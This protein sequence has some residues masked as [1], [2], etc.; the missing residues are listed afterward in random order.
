MALLSKKLFRPL[1]QNETVQQMFA[2]MEEVRMEVKMKDEEMC[3]RETVLKQVRT[4]KE[5]M[6]ASL[7]R[8]KQDLAR[9]MTQCKTLEGKL[10]Q[11]SPSNELFPDDNPEREAEL[12]GLNSQHKEHMEAIQSLWKE[13]EAKTTEYESHVAR[14]EPQEQQMNQMK[15]E[16]AQQ[17]NW[18]VSR[19]E[20]MYDLFT[21]RE[22]PVSY[23]HNILLT[24]YIY[25]T[26]LPF[27]P[28]KVKITE[29][30]NQRP[31]DFSS[32]LYITIITCAAFP[33]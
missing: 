22:K 1:L 11:S 15:E 13:Q 10:G 31:V 23:I 30:Q 26:L 29:H 6:S 16:F 4:E 20:E 24:V 9:E 19:L 17:R 12:E 18:L 5:L 28:Q 27:R 7:E 21:G 2:E 33:P 14:L 8:V 3:A 32:E 25:R